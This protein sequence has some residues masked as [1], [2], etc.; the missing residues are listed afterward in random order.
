[1]GEK[2]FL[3]LKE[4]FNYLLLFC[5]H[6]VE[7]I[8][9][10]CQ[11]SVDQMYVEVPTNLADFRGYLPFNTSS[12]ASENRSSSDG[13]VEEVSTTQATS[14]TTPTTTSTRT[15][16]RSRRRSRSMCDSEKK[17]IKP[18]I[19]QDITGNWY[20]IVQTSLY[21]QQVPVEICR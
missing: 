14:P 1:M 15:P 9:S 21:N 4:A 13:N 12:L 11:K 3:S 19:A 2:S 6:F 18:I 16:A 17:F 7:A 10:L 5:R 20:L 8:I